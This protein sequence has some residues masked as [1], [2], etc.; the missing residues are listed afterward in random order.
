MSF[1]RRFSHSRRGIRIALAA[2]FAVLLLLAV[3]PVAAQVFQKQENFDSDPQ[4]DGYENSLFDGTDVIQDFGYSSD[5]NFAGGTPGEAGGFIRR[6]RAYYADNVGALD[7]ATTPLAMSGSASFGAAGGYQGNVLVGWFDKFRPLAGNGG[8][9]LIGFVTDETEYVA[10]QIDPIRSLVVTNAAGQP[11]KEVGLVDAATPFTYDIAWDPFGGTNGTGLIT[12]TF[13]ISV[14]GTVSTWTQRIDHVTDEIKNNLP[15]SN[16]YGISALYNPSAGPNTVEFFIDD[17]NYTASVPVPD[18]TNYQWKLDGPGDW[19]VDE[20]WDLGY[21]PLNTHTTV[22]G[23]TIDRPSTIFTETDIAA[24]GLR[25][26][27][28]YTYG[29]AGPV[30][31]SLTLQGNA[32]IQVDQGT[33]EFQLPV[34]VTA[35]TTIDAAAGSSITFEDALNLGG[36]T[37]TKTGDGTMV[38]NNNASTGTGSLEVQNGTL[39]GAGKLSGDVT[40]LTGATTA[41]GTSAGMLKV[42]GNY[43]QNAGA[44]LAVEIGGTIAEQNFD[45]LQ[46]TGTA[47]LQGTLDVALI[48][49]YTPAI[50]EQFTILSASSIGGS[51]SLGGSDGGSFN[52]TQVGSTLVLEFIGGTAGTTGGLQR[53]RYR[54]RCRLHHVAR[55]FGYEQSPGERP[56]WGHH[57][58][59][60]VHPVERQFW[61]HRW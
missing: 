54:G 21:T 26:N 51:L 15:V 59:V 3:A 24:N 42:G 41:P 4:W 32:R 57:W 45:V 46:I 52:L 30:G 1:D 60:A 34:N 38:I 43:T 7:P 48:D 16:R 35:A 50:N 37:A 40:V 56:H 11:I 36:N 6:D 18:P 22:F 47:S 9:D 39:A 28:E 23:S 13:D 29:I 33:P 10:I 27:S 44:T 17:I 19:N 55:Q 25:F 8:H 2:I 20:N 49:S 12:G 31:T 14:N 61:K 53:R 58:P 5:T